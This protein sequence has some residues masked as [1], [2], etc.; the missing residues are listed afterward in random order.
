MTLPELLPIPG[1]SFLM[2]ENDDDKFAGDT[3]RPRHC[4]RL[5]PFL[6]GSA[7][8]TLREFRGFHPGHE[9]ELPADWPVAMVSWHEARAYCRW[10]AGQSG[11]AYRLPTEAEWEYAARAGSRTPYPWGETMRPDLANHWYD[12]QGG[13]VGPGHRT[14]P[15]SYPANAFGLRDMLGNLCEWVQDAW[16][17]DYHGAPEDGSAW[18]LGESGAGDEEETPRV[19]RGGAWDY[20]PRLLRVSWRDSLAACSRR[21]NVG[22]RVARPL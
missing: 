5:A 15:G 20:L 6:L 19:L 16:H 4:V 13:K 2:G 7:P 18:E 11:A 3:E 17:P 12:E 10:L 8:V 1:G 9:P 21:D 14:P 22:F